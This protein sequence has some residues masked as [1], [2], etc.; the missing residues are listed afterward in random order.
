MAKKKEPVITVRS[1][2]VGTRTDR[3]AFI[4]LI[5]EKE[6]SRVD[7]DAFSRYNEGNPNHGVHGGL[8]NYHV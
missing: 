1:V 8:E 6:K 3:Q 7:K 5:Q 4:D 2:F